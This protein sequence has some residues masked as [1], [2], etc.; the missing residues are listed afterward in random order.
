MILVAIYIY[1][2]VLVKFH[3]LIIAIT[4]PSRVGILTYGSEVV[5]EVSVVG[6]LGLA[7]AGQVL[8]NLPY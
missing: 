1:L 8:D 7:F 2:V 5:S 3:N 4:P 6:A